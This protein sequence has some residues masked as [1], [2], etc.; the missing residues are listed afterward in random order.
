MT[1]YANIIG[2]GHYVPARCVTN[3]EIERRLGEPVHDWLVQNVGI[4]QRHFMAENEVTS[5]LALAA[6]REALERAGIGPADLDLVIVATDT[7]DQPSPATAAVLQHKL[8]AV[9]AGVYDVNSACAGWVIALDIAAKTIAADE[10]YKHVLVVGAYGMSRFLDQRDKRTCTIFA[11]G[12]GAVVL[13]ADREPGFLG[14]KL[15]ADGTYHDALGVYAGGTARPSTLANVQE[16]G[17]PYVRFVRR[18]PA[19]FNTERWPRLIQRVLDRRGLQKSD[20][21]LYLFTQLN[22]RGI[23]ATMA[24]LE[25]PLDRTHW[26]MN[27]W[28]YTGSACIPMALHDAVLAG[29]VRKGD[30]VVLC[31]SGGGISLAAALVRWTV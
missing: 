9:N 20:V 2:T 8:G 14:A 30:H 15:D 11:D 10:D 7:P 31:A 22:L 23:E 19:T 3:A 13:R 25:Q 12:A 16:G 28:G 18:F 27:K 1:R 24:A 6:A 4:E 29:K 17:P 26:I 21:A 5:D